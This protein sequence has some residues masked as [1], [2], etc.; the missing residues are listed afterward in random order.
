MKGA[1]KEEYE[2]NSGDWAFC[3][4]ETGWPKISAL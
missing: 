4:K 2:F 1:F 3:A